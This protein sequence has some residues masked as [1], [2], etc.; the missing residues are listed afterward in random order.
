LGLAVFFL[1]F[2]ITCFDKNVIEINCCQSEKSFVDRKE[3]DG[4]GTVLGVMA[5]A[6]SQDVLHAAW[7]ITWNAY[8]PTTW[9]EPLSLNAQNARQVL[10][11]PEFLSFF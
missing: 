5:K 10:N 9:M 1:N 11:Q 3:T 4:T 7:C 8:L 6:A 2:C